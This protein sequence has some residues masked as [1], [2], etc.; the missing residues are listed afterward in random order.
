MIEI[1]LGMSNSAMAG[2]AAAVLFGFAGLLHWASFRGPLAAFA[3]RY[4]GVV[5]PFFTSV[6]VLFS[7]LFGFLANDVWERNRRGHRAVAVEHEALVTVHALGRVTGASAALDEAVRAYVDAAVMKEWTA[8]ARQQAAP[9]A[10]Q[11]LDILLIAAAS[12]GAAPNIERALID[13]VQRVR[14]ARAE[15]LL[16]SLQ[17]PEELR[18]ATA[19]LLALITQIC[20]AAVHLDKARPQAAALVLFTLAVWVAISLVAA[21]E[22]PFEPPLSVPSSALANVLKA[23][24]AR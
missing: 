16:L 21:Y 18:W 13:S 7:L 2:V 24:P 20:I 11:A 6:A 5:A 14:A 15:R 23:L 4:R 9:E 10:G 1:W 3:Q 17:A 12:A 19:L 22:Y 8:M